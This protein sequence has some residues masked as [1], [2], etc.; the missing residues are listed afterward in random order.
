MLALFAFLILALQHASADSFSKLGC[1]KQSDLLS[2]LSKEDSFMYQS[3]GHCQGACQGKAVAALIDGKN[4]YCGL[5]IPE[6]SLEVSSSNCD[7]PCQ[8][9]DKENLSLI[10][11]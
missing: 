9:Y 2:Y 1:F 10:H 7:S 8:G 11:I 4:C 5:S 3:L 6:L